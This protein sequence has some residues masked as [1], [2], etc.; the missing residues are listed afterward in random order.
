MK[1]PNR[2]VNNC[3]AALLML[4]VM[5]MMVGMDISVVSDRIIGMATDLGKLALIFFSV[6]GIGGGFSY[7]MQRL[8]SRK[9]LR[10]FVRVHRH[11]RWI[12]VHRI[13]WV[14]TAVI[15]VPVAVVVTLL[16]A[17]FAP[18]V[19]PFAP[20]VVA[21]PEADFAFSALLY[22]L[23]AGSYFWIFSNKGYDGL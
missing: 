15:H 4:L 18:M 7:A 10:Q 16:V 8:T 21:S 23:G 20:G 19:V 22:A 14:I 3:L 17:R 1:I 12:S 2:T 13:L 11:L 9:I 6:A 5:I